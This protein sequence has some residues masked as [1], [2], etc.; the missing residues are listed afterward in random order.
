M[1][2]LNQISVSFMWPGFPDYAARSIR[3]FIAQS[4]CNVS[5]IATKPQIPIGGME[6]SLG[7]AVVWVDGTDKTLTWEKLSLHKPHIVFQG[8]W[9]EP[10]FN[11]LSEHARRSGA[12]I[13]LM[14]DQNWRGGFRQH[15]LDPVRYR[16]FHRKKFDATLVPG[17]SAERFAH[18]VGF[19]KNKIAKGVYGADPQVFSVRTPLHLRS[20]KFIFVGQLI[21]RKNILALVEVFLKLVKLCP[22]WSLEIVGN[23]ALADK[24]SAHPQISIHGFMQPKKLAL[25][26][27]N[28]RCLVLPS[29]DE[30]W[31]VVAHEAVCCGCA[32]AL[33]RA[34]GSAA[35][36][37]NYENSVSFRSTNSVD[38]F[39]ALHKI[40][41]WTDDE[42]RRAE[43]TSLRFAENFGPAVFSA[44]AQ[45]LILQCLP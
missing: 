35:D 42:W 23:G 32:L 5:V 8:G 33:S 40:T 30:H 19:S 1:A 36:L 22:E 45:S 21:A 6:N 43:A 9:S 26:L 16:L 37:A 20:K 38:M 41:K 12:K 34:I 14:N 31:G 4:Q 39:E 15:V 7:Q 44:A 10:A 18:A 27:Q 17:K 24:L 13:I 29:H 3:H 25:L 28:S 11:I 2:G